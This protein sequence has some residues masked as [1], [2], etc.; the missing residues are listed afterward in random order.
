MSLKRQS[1]TEAVN[2]SLQNVWGP[3]RHEKFLPIKDYKL[4]SFL[5]KMN[6]VFFPKARIL[7]VSTLQGGEHLSRSR[8]RKKPALQI[9]RKRAHLTEGAARIKDLRQQRDRPDQRS[10]RRL[11]LT[12]SC[13]KIKSELIIKRLEIWNWYHNKGNDIE[14]FIQFQDF[15]SWTRHYCCS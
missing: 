12:F 11:P 13:I 2:A 3:K 7:W 6:I 9:S 15:I 1:G 14:V 4:V 10:P 8:D 5:L